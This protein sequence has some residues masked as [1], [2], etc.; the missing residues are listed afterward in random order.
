MVGLQILYTHAHAHTHAHTHTQKPQIEHH[1]L[2]M[3]NVFGNNYYVFVNNMHNIGFR[4]IAMF[5][6]VI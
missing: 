4:C 1:Y 5:N 6:L 3:A 2:P